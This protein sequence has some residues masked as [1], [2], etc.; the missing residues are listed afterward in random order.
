MQKESSI[1]TISGPWVLA[2]SRSYN[3]RNKDGR[4]SSTFIVYFL[5]CVPGIEDT[6]FPFTLRK[7][8]LFLMIILSPISIMSHFRRI[9]RVRA[10]EI[11]GHRFSSPPL[12]EGI[13]HHRRG[14]VYRKREQ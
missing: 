6:I 10:G 12:S 2:N 9:E 7:E 5:G 3:I 8:M 11:E 4:T 1:K 13:Q 14:M